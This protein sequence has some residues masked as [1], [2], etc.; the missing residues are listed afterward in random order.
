MVFLKIAILKTFEIFTT[1]HLCWGT[2]SHNITHC[3]PA[4]LLKWDSCTGPSPEFCTRKP[5]NCF[6]HR[7]PVNDCIVDH[8]DQKA[9]TQL[10]FQDFDIELRAYQV[11][12]S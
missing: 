7:K 9:Y 1:K 12:F 8:T 3:R 4:T 5:V 2:F 10:N 11:I 6:S